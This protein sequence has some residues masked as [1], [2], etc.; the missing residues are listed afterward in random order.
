VA[1]PPR[2]EPQAQVPDLPQEVLLPGQ[3]VPAD[4]DST[5]INPNGTVM[6]RGVTYYIASSRAGDWVTPD[7]DD[8]TIRFI[9]DYGEVLLEHNWPPR[10]T[11][12]VGKRTPPSPMS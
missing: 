4:D 3:D 5:A 6:F 2:P 9:D 10:G 11:R 12:Y 8:S 1:E 7:W